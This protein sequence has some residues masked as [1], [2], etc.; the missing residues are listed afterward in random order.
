[1]ADINHFVEFLRLYRNDPVL[2]VREVFGVTPDPW[3]GEMMEAVASGKRKISVKSGHGVGKSSASSWLMLWYLLTRYPVK[4]VVTA[5]TSAQ[6]YDAL[7]AECRRWVNEMP[8]QL[9]ALLVVKSDR[10]ELAAAPAEAFISCRVSR[11]ETPE[12]LQGIHSE[13]VLLCADEAS[14]VPEAVFIASSGSMS[15]KNATTLLL[16]NPTRGSGYFFD[17]HN[18]LNSD[19]WTRTVNCED[20]PRVS[21]EY[22][23]EMRKRF[24]EDSNDFRVR[25]LGEFPT[26][27]DD[28]V[29]S[30]AT[31][32]AAMSR[33]VPDREEGEMVWGLDVARHGDDQSALCKRMGRVVTEIQCWKKL[34]LMQLCG[35]VKAEYDALPPSRQPKS[36]IIDSVALGSGVLDRLQEL[37]LPAIGCNVSESPSAG[38]QYANLRAELW[39]GKLKAFLEA[40][41]CRLPRNDDLMAELVA[42]KYSF[43]SNG[44]LKI[45]SKA[46]LKRRGHKS[47]DM[48]DSI[49]LSLAYENTVMMHGSFAS[50]KWKTPIR[51][52]LRGMRVA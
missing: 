51:R 31:V 4:V 19:W 26:Q 41:D 7:F 47:P 10:I 21:D 45:E 48:A 44:K 14:G 52:N 12:A 20:S 35:V 29:L 34:D 25:V 49:M 39:H 9:K 23:E 33:D 8:D 46:D 40:R 43:T 11:V 42:P 27:D 28:T 15:G 3:Q 37:Q 16:G 17:T 1:M 24:G 18:K 32:D 22:V 5:P 38:T 50:N 13:H 30:W 36:I 2:F 6:L